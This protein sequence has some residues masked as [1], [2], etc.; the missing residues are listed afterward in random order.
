MRKSEG[1]KRHGQAGKPFLLMDHGFRMVMVL[2]VMSIKIKHDPR[3]EWYNTIN[4]IIWKMPAAD[5][6][7]KD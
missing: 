1:A 7:Q 3:L 5:S 6:T 2:R 4:R